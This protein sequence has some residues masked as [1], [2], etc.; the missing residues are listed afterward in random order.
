[1]ESR[2]SAVCFV[3]IYGQPQDEVLRQ[4]FA[5]RDITLI[6]AT[7][8]TRTFSEARSDRRFPI[9]TMRATMNYFRRFP[10]WLFPLLV[11]G[12]FVVHAV[13][14]WSMILLRIREIKRADVVV[15][16]HM[17]DTSVLIAKP[18]AIVLG[19]PLVYFSHNGMYVTLISNRRLFDPGSV[20]ARTV[21]LLD[22]LSHVLSDRV[23]VFSEGSKQQFSDIY[24]IPENRYEVIYIS[25]IKDDFDKS[26]PPDDDLACDVLYWGNFHPHHGPKTMVRAAT[27]VPE[28][29]FVFAGRSQKRDPVMELAESLDADNVEFPG[30]V[31]SRQLVQYIKKADVVLGPVADNPQTEFTIGTKVAE[32]AYMEKAI[33][34]ARQPATSE[35]FTHPEDAYL[36][37]PGDPDALAKAVRTILADVEL[38]ER[39][40][41]GAHEAY[42]RHFSGNRAVSRFLEIAEDCSG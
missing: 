41:R 10:S 25:V 14:T 26:T 30:F 42:R 11:I 34:V 6:E 12:T 16:P 37:E 5:E 18:L 40:E 22:R 4:G 28:A 23:V 8:T 21:Y 27:T 13:A 20:A 7:V 29:R 3:G 19:V 24:R 1:M 39:L 32:A 31:S 36:V 17:G 9:M 15:V 2:I 33:V 38:Q 35:T